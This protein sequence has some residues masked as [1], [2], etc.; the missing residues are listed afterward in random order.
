MYIK[1]IVKF[2]L[3]RCIFEGLP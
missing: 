3:S 1:F 2:F